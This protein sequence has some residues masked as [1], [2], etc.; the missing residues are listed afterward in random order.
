MKKEWLKIS[1]DEG[2]SEEET[3]EQIRIQMDFRFYGILDGDGNM[4][5]DRPEYEGYTEWD[6][7]RVSYESGWKK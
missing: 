3:E 7:I 1:E 5:Y 6:R 4:P 2:L